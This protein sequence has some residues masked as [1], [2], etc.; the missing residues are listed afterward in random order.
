MAEEGDKSEK[1]SSAM[2][3]DNTLSPRD[4]RRFRG[5]AQ[6]EAL[7]HAL[8]SKWEAPANR[9]DPITIL[10]ES[11][12]GRIESLSPLRYGRMLQ[13]PFTFY[14]GAA[15]IMAADLAS[16]PKMDVKVQACG[17]CHLQNFGAFATPERN[18]IFDINDFDETLPAPWEWDVK[19]LAASFVLAIRHNNVK[20]KYEAEAAQAVARAYRE[21]MGEFARMSI[22]D[23]WYANVNW[24]N[25]VES[26]T[27]LELQKKHNKA[28]NK[29]MRR[30]IQDYYFPK[31]TEQ[32]N[33]SYVFKDSPPTIYHLPVEDEE[34]FRDQVVR[35]LEKYK[36]TMQEDRGRLLSR[37]KLA[38]FAIKVVGIGSV[39]TMCAIILMMAPDNEPLVLQ[40]KEARESVLEP[41]AGKSEFDNHGQRVVAGQRIVQSASDIFLGWTEFDDGKQFYLRQLRDTKIKADTETWEGS[42]FVEIAHTMGSVL[43]RAHARS[44][45]AAVIR[46]YLGSH[47]GF[48]EAIGEFSIA[49]SD[50]TEKDHALLVKAVD[51]GRIKATIEAPEE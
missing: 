50:Q 48:D 43:A 39:G 31:M 19:R 3:H 24:Q 36:K 7:P 10:E 32:M 2:L 14:R 11:N 41:Y 17:D 40:L 1:K 12:V 5:R 23:I 25:F 4:D 15:A 42:H 18:V 22:L 45:D 26:T 33:G 47:T 28:L 30:T 9:R 27:D 16:T 37:Y 51:S 38:D 46:G 35:A 34:A 6:R 13:S 8:H 44:G 20:P 21:R 29:A 49:Y